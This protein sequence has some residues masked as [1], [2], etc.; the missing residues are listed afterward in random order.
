MAQRKD[1]LVEIGTEELP[2]K[3]LRNLAT[4]FAAGIEQGLQQAGVQFEKVKYYATPRRL[5][6]LVSQLEVQ[7]PD[8][9][10]E[11]RGPALAAAFDQEGMPSKALQ[12]FARSCGVEVEALERLETEKGAWL[13]YRSVLVGRSTAELVPE[14]VEKSLAALPI[15]K[16]MRWADFKVEFVR[17]AHWIVLLFGDEVIDAQ[18]LGIKAG[19]ETRGHRFHHPQSLYIAEPAAYAPLLETEGQVIADFADR[20]E[21]VLGQVVEAAVKVG[22]Q[23]VIDEALLDEV[24]ALVEWPV[25]ICGRFEERYLAVPEECLISSMQGHQ[26]YFPVRE[27][28][29]G[30]LMPYFITVANIVSS[31]VASIIA[32][33][34]RVIR[35]R[36]EDAMFFFERDKE[37]PLE[38][39][40]EQLKTVVFQKQLGTV[41]EKVER[42]R[43][44][45][46]HIAQLLGLSETDSAKVARAAMLAKCDL[47]TGMVG[48]FP[49]LQGLM[50]KNYALKQGEDAVVAQALDEQYM[51]KQA[52]G[53][54]PSSTVGDALAMADKLDTLCGIFAVGLIPTGDKD[55]FALRRAALGILR[56]IIEKGH[57]VDLP[58]LI[59]TAAKPFA[60]IAQDG[61]GA[62]VAFNDLVEQIHS[63]VVDRLRAYFSDRGISSDVFESV[64][65]RAPRDPSDFAKRIN[66]VTAFRSMLEAESLAAANKRI[67]N[68][69]RQ[70]PEN[71]PMLI[72]ASLL[73][74][75]EERA[76]SQAIGKVSDTVLP[77]LEKQDYTVALAQMAQLREAVD[78]FF[79]HVMVMA[80][81]EALKLNRIALIKSLNALFLRV[82]D[83]SKLQG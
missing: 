14:I 65:A 8:Q 26:K 30:K 25:A 63:Y 13:V 52:G 10:Q 27:K 57:A 23:A 82:A 45:S 70:A 51:P 49:E 69:L 48:E 1:L 18:I 59:A 3:A 83:L 40:N 47:V 34:E 24:T 22:G 29:T 2:P 64:L 19:R 28:A 72:N 21:A 17:P 36:L 81:D 62:K 32:G 67:S 4:A 74:Q 16:R 43:D 61:K 79:D 55:P 58:S 39:R 44:L 9:Q 73:Q 6:V 50:G 78:A 56:L 60:D 38:A 53:E 80:D 54:L 7:Q 35:P 75:D 76:L 15:P 33:N 68:I 20:R 71:V 11:R 42:V 77:L 5:A 41:Y 46:V 37:R 12:G 66:A 31:N